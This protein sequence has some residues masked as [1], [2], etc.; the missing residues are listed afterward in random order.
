[1]KFELIAA[2]FALALLVFMPSHPATG[3]EQADLYQKSV[4]FEVDKKYQESLDELEKISGA[5][6]SS[7]AF[8]L[9]KGWLLYLLGKYEKAITSY[10]A[11]V[12]KEPRSV[13]ALLGLMPPQMAVR[14]W[15]D[16]E[17]TGKRILKLDPGS[18]LANSRLAYIYYSLTRFDEAEKYYKKLVNHY[19][20]DVEMRSGYGWSL[21]KQGNYEEAKVQ[22]KK[23]IAFAPKHAAALEGL[24][25]C[26]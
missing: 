7:Y 14:K 19:P 16:A 22:F 12:A 21:F 15:V 10:K 5:L 3:D 26:P 9:R 4:D 6:K 18:Y 13:E 25:Y 11:A 8:Q 17:K 24:K 20:G 2:A 1:M 23:I